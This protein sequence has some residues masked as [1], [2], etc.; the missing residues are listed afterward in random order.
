MKVKLHSLS[1]R[2]GFTILELG[3]VLVI[4]AMVTYTVSVSFDAFVPRERINTSV[5][6]LADVL[7]QARSESVSRNSEYFVEYD[8]VEHRYRM[9]TPLSLNGQ[10]WIEGVDPEEFRRAT[11]WEHLR[12]GVVF[13]S[14]TLAGTIYTEEL[15]RVRFDPL[16]LRIRP[17]RSD[18]PTA[19]RDILHTGSSAPHGLD[20][21]PR[22]D[23]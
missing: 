23:L 20:P 6:D 14:V 22:R 11:N 15:V 18:F 19:V 12:Q 7:R 5:R 16:G 17:H 10:P 13:D 1:S 4:M 8:M 21:L 2:S 3:I 9:I